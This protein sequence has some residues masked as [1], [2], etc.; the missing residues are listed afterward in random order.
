MTAPLLADSAFRRNPV[1]RTP[2]RRLGQPEDLSFG[3]LYLGSDES[4]FVTG[5]ERVI[6]GFPTA[7]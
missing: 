2:L 6:D 3:V 1:D 5:S 4:S 7:E